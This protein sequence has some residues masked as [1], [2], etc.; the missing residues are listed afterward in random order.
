[1]VGCVICQKNKLP[2]KEGKCPQGV[3]PQPVGQRKQIEK[4][5]N[6]GESVL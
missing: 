6:S 5:L 3:M 4:Q 2:E 1:M